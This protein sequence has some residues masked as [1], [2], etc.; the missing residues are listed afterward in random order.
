MDEKIIY[1]DEEDNVIGSKSR[2]D[3]D[4]D[5]LRYRISS[6]W[7]KNSKGG[8]LL[9]RRALTKKHNP[10]KWG[11]AVAGTIDEGE[12]YRGNVIKEAFEELGIK[13]IEIK[14][15]L[16]EKIDGVQK[17]FVQWF[18]A[19]IDKPVEDFVIQKEEVE[20]VKW[21][22]KEE[23]DKMVRDKPEDFIEGMSRIIEAFY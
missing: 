1:V 21:F 17:F 23:F 19:V 12:S 18:S 8:S 13:D 10:G 7:V 4:K 22:S 11:T 9:A 14:L 3:V 5:G 6:L 15:E 2:D 16:K 20:E